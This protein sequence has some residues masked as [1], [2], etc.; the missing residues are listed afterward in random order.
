ML[1][2]TLSLLTLLIALLPAARGALLYP[3][4][5][6]VGAMSAGALP[7]TLVMSQ[8]YLP[9]RTALGGG[10]VLAASGL[11]ALVAAPLGVVADAAGL[12]AAIYLT[13]G[14]AALATIFAARL[15]KAG[16]PAEGVTVLAAA[17]VQEESEASGENSPAT[18]RWR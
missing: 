13:A 17:P 1:V 4:L 9:G 8:E 16:R 7:V 10:L 11:A 2:L 15:P 14:L 5:F 18:T 12:R 3:E 6:L